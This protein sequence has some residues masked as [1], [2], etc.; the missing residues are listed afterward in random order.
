MN[1][2]YSIIYVCRYATGTSNMETPRFSIASI[3]SIAINA[4]VDTVG[5]DMVS[6]SF[7]KRFCLLTYAHV[8]TLIFLLLFYLIKWIDSSAH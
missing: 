2:F 8:L 4:S 1:F 3:N 7:R 6:T 5:Y